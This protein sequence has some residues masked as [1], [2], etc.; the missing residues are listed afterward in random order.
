VQNSQRLSIEFVDLSAT[1]A[2]LLA[3]AI[4]DREGTGPKSLP[5]IAR[6]DV[7]KT[8]ADT[9]DNWGKIWYENSTGKKAIAASPSRAD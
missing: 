2:P 7:W 4:G 6:I 3:R 1:I 5:S 8:G 9:L